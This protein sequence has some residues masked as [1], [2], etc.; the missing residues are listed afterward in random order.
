[1]EGY[2]GENNDKNKG[3][4]LNKTPASGASENPVNTGEGNSAADSSVSGEG[5]TQEYGSSGN[6]GGTSEGTS[7]ADSNVSGEG[8]AQESGSSGTTGGHYGDGGT[9]STS[10]VWN[11]SE[12]SGG[13][14][15][16]TGNSDT[17]GTGG[18]DGQS[19]YNPYGGNVQYK[20]NY[21]DYQKALNNN[22]KKPKKKGLRAFLITICSVAGVAL[23]SL[24]VVGAMAILKNNGIVSIGDSVGTSSATIINPNGPSLKLNSKPSTSVSSSSTS[25]TSTGI[26]MT[27][28]QVYSKV[29]DSVVV[30]E[31]YDM[32]S[33]EAT[34][35]GSGI[36]MSADGYIITNEHVIDGAKNVKVILPN[37]KEYTAKVIG[38]D[39]RTDLAVLKIDATGLSAATFGSSDQLG[40]AESVLAIGNSAGLGG[41]VTGGIISALNMSVTTENNYTEKCIQTDAP[42]NPGNSGG[43]LVNMYGQVVGITSSKIEAAGYEGMGFA[44]PINTAKPIIDDIIKYGYVTGRVKIGISVREYDAT[45]A[46]AQGYPAGLLVAGVDSSSDAASK[47]LKTND[48]ITKI[49]GVSAT[50]YD[51]FYAEESKYKAGQTVTLTVYRHSTN[52]TFTVSIKLLEDKGDTSTATSSSSSGNSNGYSKGYSNGYSY[53]NYNND[54]S[55]SESSGGA[56]G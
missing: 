16:G 32:T 38:S 3:D 26:N 53:G 51:A 47:G 52:Q 14:Y 15:G 1:M 7:A 2:F 37:K 4:E 18:A 23:V 30:I 21:D 6:T 46:A 29:K 50:T 25:S 13:Y 28:Q 20:W 36:I 39:K 12:S 19:E 54:Y 49:N 41:S 22:G 8:N 43:A 17:Q 40:I 10:G 5:N 9:Y 24:A 31:T 45:M 42:I 35:A 55:G 44:I 48:I 33:I 56:N 27:A 34:G 11:S